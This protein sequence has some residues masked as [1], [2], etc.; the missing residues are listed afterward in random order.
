MSG[1]G[2]WIFYFA[3]LLFLS[4]GQLAR[5]LLT[6]TGGFSSRYAALITVA[7]LIVVAVAHHRQV[8]IRPRVIW[9]IICVLLGLTA[10]GTFFLGGFILF[11]GAILPASVLL[12]GAALLL[13]SVILVYDY[14]YRQD[15]LWTRP[16][17]PLAG[18]R[19]PE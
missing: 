11:A 2:F 12:V 18:E 17:A 15:E 3:V 16:A 13:P 10:F 8:A 6:D 1:L 4:A 19:P 9:K 14:A 7:V 5:K